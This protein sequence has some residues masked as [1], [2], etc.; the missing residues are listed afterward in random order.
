MSEGGELAVQ[1]AGRLGLFKAI[2]G[3]FK[4]ALKLGAEDAGK[5]VEKDL[6]KEL[7]KDLEKLDTTELKGF[8][9][10]NLPGNPCWRGNVVKYLTRRNARSCSSS[11]RTVSSMMPRATSSTRRAPRRSTRGRAARSS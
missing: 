11:S 9:G 5:D 7:T 3:F 1:E 4:K 10:E 2:A 8:Q 6:D